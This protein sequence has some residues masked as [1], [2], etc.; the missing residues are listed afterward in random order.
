MVTGLPVWV[1][2]ASEWLATCVLRWPADEQEHTRRNH[3]I[4]GVSRPLISF[5][6]HYLL[7]NVEVP[8]QINSGFG[9]YIYFIC[10]CD[11]PSDANDDFPKI[12]VE[13]VN[14]V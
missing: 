7:R 5:G 6:L 1:T 14:T 11:H 13:D 10:N 2:G 8:L 3:H 12:A 9:R 4:F